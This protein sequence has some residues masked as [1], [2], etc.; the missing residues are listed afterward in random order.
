M[1]KYEIELKQLRKELREK[2]S[3]VNEYNQTKLK[4]MQTEHAKK[5]AI[6]ALAISR[7]NFFNE[8]DKKLELQNKIKMM[9][10]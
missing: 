6:N 2:N 8:R 1:R 3:I 4:Q 9:A 7:E 5:T 10:S